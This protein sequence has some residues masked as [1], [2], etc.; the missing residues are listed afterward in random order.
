MQKDGQKEEICTG[1]SFLL[2]DT[3]TRVKYFRIGEF[4]HQ[5]K[6]SGVVVKTG[7]RNGDAFKGMKWM[8][9]TNITSTLFYG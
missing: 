4:K 6:F 2:Q 1:S 9:Q 8:M 5:I 3:K 7:E